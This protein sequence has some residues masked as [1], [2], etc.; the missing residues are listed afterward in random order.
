MPEVKVRV[1]EVQVQKRRVVAL[2][3]WIPAWFFLGIS[4]LADAVDRLGGEYSGVAAV[5]FWFGLML[6]PYSVLYAISENVATYLDLACEGRGAG[7]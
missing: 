1:E 4:W 7:G 5:F 6:F 2:E 3:Y